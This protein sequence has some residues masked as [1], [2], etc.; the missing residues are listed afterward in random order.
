MM[1]GEMIEDGTPEERREG[2][3]LLE[4]VPDP[5]K[6]E[7]EVDPGLTS[8]GNVGDAIDHLQERGTETGTRVLQRVEEDGH[9]STG[10]SL[11]GALSIFHLF[12]L[13]PCRLLVKSPQ[14]VC[15]LLLWDRTLRP[16]QSPH[17]LHQLPVR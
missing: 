16:S 13:K 15:L 11:L 5:M 7:E 10:M 12:S 9:Q 2:G 6:E 3:D 8:E 14:L 17:P 1:G 4:V